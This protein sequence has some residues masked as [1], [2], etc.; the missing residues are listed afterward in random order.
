[1]YKKE[2]GIL[3]GTFDPIHNGHLKLA[4]NAKIQGELDEVW[5]VP[6][7]NPPHKNGRKIS[8]IVHRLNM[9]YLAIE[10]HPEFI[11]SEIELERQEA[12]YTFKTLEMLTERY[13][14]YRFSFI[15]GAD[16]FY[17]LERWKNPERIMKL[18][19]LLVAARDYN[20]V[21]NSL[22]EEALKKKEK[23]GADILFI[24]DATIDI[25]SGRLREM[26]ENGRKIVKYV[27]A[28]VL[29]YIHTHHLYG[30]ET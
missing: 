16:S 2:I 17:E 21:G 19:R 4:Q 13:P 11:C 26:L 9:I 24:S 14:R 28:K 7:P 10:N 5:F 27:P 20:L 18:C 29:Q 23:Y 3:G 12:S 15:M 1:M 30:E 25:S 22:Q 8:D 6:A